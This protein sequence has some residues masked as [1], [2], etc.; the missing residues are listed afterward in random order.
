MDDS[1]GPRT[2]LAV[3]IYV[4]HDVMAHQFLSL[5]GDFIIDI[6]GVSL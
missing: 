2:L 1:F 6:V 4:G 3:G 5:T